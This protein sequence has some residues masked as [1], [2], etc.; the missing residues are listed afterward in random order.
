MFF[1]LL[2]RREAPIRTENLPQIQEQPEIGTN[3]HKA[4]P[5]LGP[6]VWPIPGDLSRRK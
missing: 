2:W 3:V 5:E 1:T 4:A 6:A